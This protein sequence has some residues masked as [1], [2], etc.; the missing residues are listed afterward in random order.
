ME[1]NITNVQQAELEITLIKKIMEDS[2]KVVYNSSIQGIYWTFVMTPAIIL[3]YLMYIYKF[4]LA[5]VGILWITAVAVGTAGSIIIARKERRM[6]RVKTFAGKLLATIGIAIGGA[7]IMFSIA[8]GLA[9]AFHPIYIVSVDSVVMGMG[10]YVIGVIQQLKTL[11]I[12]SF[13]WWAGAIFFFVFPSIHCLL[14]LAIMLILTI[15][16]P[17]IEEK[18]KSKNIT[19]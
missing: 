7:N 11:K 18:N 19:A 14:F 8:S 5:Y 15:L 9:H 2:R 1:H 17:R 3:N 4:G 10:F 16:L 6:V 13:I 12:L